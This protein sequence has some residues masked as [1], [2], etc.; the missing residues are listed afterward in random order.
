MSW[1]LVRLDALEEAGGNRAEAVE[2]WERP[3]EEWERFRPTAERSIFGLDG[4]FRAVVEARWPTIDEMITAI[5]RHARHRESP[6]F[7]SPRDFAA[8]ERLLGK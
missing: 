3:P 7:L 6:I 1:F 4:T 2:Q 5:D 8:Y